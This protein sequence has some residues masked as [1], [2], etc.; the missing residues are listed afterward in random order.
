VLAAGQPG[1]RVALLTLAA[2]AGIGVMLQDARRWPIARR[3]RIAVFAVAFGGGFLG[4]YLPA[5]V[6]G[7]L[8]GQIARSGTVPMSI[9][10]ALFFSFLAV[11]A[12]K[13]SLGIHWDTSD[14]FARGLTLQMAIGRLGCHASHCCLGVKTGAA[15]GMDFG[16]G[17]PRVP[18]QLIEAAV[19]FALFG[20]FSWLEA[21]D[22]LPHRRLFLV[23]VAYG[24]ARFVL[25]GW[26]EP[27]GAAWLGLGAYRWFALAVATL[28]LY[29]VVKRT[30]RVAREGRGWA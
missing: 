30:R 18:I 5:L 6:A 9:L 8:A 7:G 24:L 2:V 25:E 4:A 20:V 3:Q 26:R 23:F 19:M 22:R 29:Q 15:W 13:R 16:D 27:M 28:G 11:A 21:G 1:V 12:Y 10:G 17:V 14:A